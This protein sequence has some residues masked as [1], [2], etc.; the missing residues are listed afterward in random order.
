MSGFY[1]SPHLPPDEAKLLNRLLEQD[2]LVREK[3]IEADRVMCSPSFS[4]G[5]NGARREFLNLVVDKTL[6]GKGGELTEKAIADILWPG[7]RY[8]PTKNSTIRVRSRS[9]RTGLKR[10][11]KTAGVS[12]PIQIEFPEGLWTPKFVDLRTAVLVDVRNMNQRD[13]DQNVCECFK[14]E[15]VSA[16]NQFPGLKASAT[17]AGGDS[18]KQL[19]A[20]AIFDSMDDKIRLHTALIDPLTGRTLYWDDRRGKREK[21]L[22][23]AQT[24]AIALSRAANT[25]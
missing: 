1:V 7:K 2:S 25:H 6:I 4:K 24:W 3:K 15:A 11:Y 16:L 10:F 21:H 17:H 13:V 8:D 14:A 19:V 12:G 23:L 20:Q 5:S 9:V 22:R 18:A